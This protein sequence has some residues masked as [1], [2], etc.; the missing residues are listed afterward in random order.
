MEPVLVL[1]QFTL[2]RKRPA[3]QFDEASL[4]KIFLEQRY[5]DS[6]GHE[7]DTQ[8]RVRLHHVSQYHHHEVRLQ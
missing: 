4:T 8:L 6:G 1:V 5:I 2:Y 3:L 7:N